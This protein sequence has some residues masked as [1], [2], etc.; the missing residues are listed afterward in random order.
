MEALP[1]PLW[2]SAQARSFTHICQALGPEVESHLKMGLSGEP[3]MDLLR[4]FLLTHKSNLG[5]V[6][7][8]S[9]FQYHTFI[10]FHFGGIFCSK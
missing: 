9:F 4:V 1:T 10:Y 8:Y 6:L 3:E 5:T 2:A 7:A